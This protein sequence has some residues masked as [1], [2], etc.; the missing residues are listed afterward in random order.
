MAAD[1]LAVLEAAGE[2]R[3][4]G[5]LFVDG[6]DEALKAAFLAEFRQAWARACPEAPLARV[7]WAGEHDVDEILAAYQGISMF[8]PRELTIVVGVEKLVRSEKKIAALAEG[9]S[10]SAGESCLVFV[11]AAAD[12]TRKSLEPLRGACA[13]RWTAEPRESG[14]LIGWGRR[15]LAAA[16]LTAAPGTLEAL[17]ESCEGDSIAFFNELGKLVTLAGREST[18]TP[19][20]VRSLVPPTLG[21]GLEEYLAAVAVGQAGIAAQKLGRMLAEGVSEGQVV[22]ALGNLV[23]GALGGWARWRNLSGT[24]QR[25]RPGRELARALDAVY[26]AEA[27]WK[28]GRVDVVAALEQATRDVAGA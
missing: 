21:A 27:A 23:G 17:L 19:E 28:G 6:P 20:H 1:A 4:P 16:G 18:V 10:R 15:R 14:S 9:A 11:E 22:F 2:N 7:M 3:F 25:R 13:M 12:E 8:T 5:T 26:R 24:L